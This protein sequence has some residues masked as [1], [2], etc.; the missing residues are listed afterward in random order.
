MHGA[1]AL[2]RTVSAASQTR[3]LNPLTALSVLQALK[4]SILA[5][6]GAPPALKELYAEGAGGAGEG[7]KKEKQEKQE[8]KKRTTRYQ[9]DED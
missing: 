7:G 2:T 6:E 1:L 8:K 4:D 5:D 9:G 3:S